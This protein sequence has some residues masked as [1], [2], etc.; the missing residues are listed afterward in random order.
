MRPNCTWCNK[1]CKF[2]FHFG[3]SCKIEHQLE[4]YKKY[5]NNLI[6]YLDTDVLVNENVFLNTDYTEM[7]GDNDICFEKESHHS[8]PRWVSNVN[9]GFTLCKPTK[10]II[11]FYTTVLDVLTKKNTR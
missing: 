2:A 9:I 8:T 4:L 3:E 1:S 11:D 6:I 10:K 7:L 5:P